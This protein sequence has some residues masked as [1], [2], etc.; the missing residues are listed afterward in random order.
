MFDDGGWPWRE[1]LELPEL[2]GPRFVPICALDGLIEAT[3]N[4]LTGVHV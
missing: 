2:V 1:P 3:H 4:V